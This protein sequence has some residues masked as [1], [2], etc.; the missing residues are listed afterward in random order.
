MVD[1]DG[2]SLGA[3]GVDIDGRAPS[4]FDLINMHMQIASREHVNVW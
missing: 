1:C 2:G 3:E 4:N